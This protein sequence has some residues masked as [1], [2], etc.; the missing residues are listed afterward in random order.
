MKKVVELEKTIQAPRT[1]VW[2][3]MVAPR[4]ALFPDADVQT[5]WQVGHP[6]RISG[7]WQGKAYHDSGEVV[8]VEPEA[9]LEFHHWTGTGARP[10]D[11]HTVVYAL[12]GKGDATTVTL[13]QY[14]HGSK[15]LDDK[16]RKEFESTW[17]ALLDHLK[18]AVEAN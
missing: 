16:T 6:I 10:D 18:K 3:A 17:T 9:R 15:Q 12:S 1:A 8:A 7:K 13:T 2:K 4:S 5:D 11:Y 14:N